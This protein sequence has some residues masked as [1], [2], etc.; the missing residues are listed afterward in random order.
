MTQKIIRLG[1]VALVVFLAACS[2]TQKS[3]KGFDPSKVN[4][5]DFMVP[6]INEKCSGN[7]CHHGNPS[8]LLDYDLISSTVESGK[9]KFLVLESKKMPKGGELS[10]EELS[11]VNAWIANGHPK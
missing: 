8:D 3:Q 11:M 9:F 7:D 5:T 4:F 10:P 2:A 1:V 6:L